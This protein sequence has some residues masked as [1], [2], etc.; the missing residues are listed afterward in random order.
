[1]TIKTIVL[2]LASDKRLAARREATFKL[3]VEH[4]AM[5]VGVAPLAP[6]VAAIYGEMPISVELIED[7]MR[8]GRERAETLTRELRAAGERANVATQQFVEEGESTDVLA[9]HAASADL[10][11]LA[12]DAP[13]EA[14]AVADELALRSAAPVLF[15]PYI[16]AHEQIGR[17]IVVG[18]NGA[19]EA[20]RAMRDALPFLKRAEQ[21][22]LVAAELDERRRPELDRATAFLERHGVAAQAR[23]LSSVD[24][25][26]GDFLL[27]AL[28]DE[29]ADLLVMGAYGHSRL[30]ELALGGATRHVL[31]SM[32]A[33]VLMSH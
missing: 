15:I 21:V 30:R 1:M 10:L 12:Q 22:T 11:V 9:R 3:A 23:H 33:P 27:N 32:T 4:G 2:H 26:A 16:G 24:V 20:A 14:P 18:W 5:V 25:G 7:Q 29:S 28:A 13:G 17:R 19:R 8:Q 6:P 31:R